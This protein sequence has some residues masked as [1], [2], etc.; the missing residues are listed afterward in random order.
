MASI[1]QKERKE[2]QDPIE[3]QEDGKIL[4]RVPHFIPHQTT[5]DRVEILAWHIKEG[6]IVVPDAPLV[7]CEFLGDDWHITMPLLEY[8]PL[9]VL[10][11]EASCGQIVH[12]HDPLILWEPV[13]A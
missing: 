12:L 10:K 7:H 1:K 11:I 4:F 9:R 5:P 2:V 13:L 6:D 8:G 3:K